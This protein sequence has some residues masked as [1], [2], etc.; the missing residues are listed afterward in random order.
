[1][2]DIDVSIVIPSYNETAEM[3]MQ[4]LD[5]V[6]AYLKDQKYSY[7]VILVDDG[8]TNNSLPKVKE[9]IKKLKGYKPETWRYR[10]DDIRVFYEIDDKEVLILMISANLRKDSY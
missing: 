8:S 2:S 3:K 5:D 6:F 4:A 1:M 9:H 7:E 10:I